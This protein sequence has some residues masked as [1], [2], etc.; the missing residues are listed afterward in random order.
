[1]KKL[2][3]DEII[4]DILDINIYKDKK[5]SYIIKLGNNVFL[6]YLLS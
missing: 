5:D 3:D 2:L 1:M 6:Y 4:N